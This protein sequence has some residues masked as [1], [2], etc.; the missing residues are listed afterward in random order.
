MNEAWV[1]AQFPV[2]LFAQ[3]GRQR[4]FYD[5]QRIF[6]ADDW[7]M[8]GYSHDGLK[9]GFER[10]GHKVHLFGAY[11]QNVDNIDEGGTRFS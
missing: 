4:L 6:G 3:L 1:K 8:T 11:N 2:G 10:A 7:S 9:L 5:D